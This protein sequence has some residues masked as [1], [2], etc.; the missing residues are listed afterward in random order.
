M[1]HFVIYANIP[2]YPQTVG[3]LLYLVGLYFSRN[4]VLYDDE[5][6]IEDK[7]KVLYTEENTETDEDE[8]KVT[9]LSVSYKPENDNENEHVLFNKENTTT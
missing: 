2:F 8:N 1:F 9:L 6:K 4:S 7:N 3:I 5:D